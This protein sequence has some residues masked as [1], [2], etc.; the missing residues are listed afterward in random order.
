MGAPAVTNRPI[1]HGCLTVLQFTNCLST[2]NYSCWYKNMT[3]YVSQTIGLCIIALSEYMI[4]S[5][6]VFFTAYISVLF[7]LRNTF[8]N[9]KLKSVQVVTIEDMSDLASF[10]AL[11]FKW[12]W[13]IFTLPSDKAKHMWGCWE[14]M[15][16]FQWRTAVS[17]NPHH[18]LSFIIKTPKTH[19]VNPT[20]VAMIDLHQH[21]SSPLLK[22]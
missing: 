19:Q 22:N 18:P 9:K 11:P 2:C 17:I 14:N 8:H 7:S 21:K 10:F 15:L 1:P 5:R 16:P 6:A 20:I 4:I 3:W 13:L 12:T